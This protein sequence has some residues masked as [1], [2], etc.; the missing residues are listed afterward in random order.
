V[1]VGID[2]YSLYLRCVSDFTLENNLAFSNIKND[3]LAVFE[4]KEKKGRISWKGDY[5]NYSLRNNFNLIFW[6]ILSG[7]PKF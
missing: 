7:V 4:L 3:Y 6:S 1:V 2:R 5:S